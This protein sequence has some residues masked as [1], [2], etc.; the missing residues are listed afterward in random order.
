MVLSS[1][2]D[3]PDSDMVKFVLEQDSVKR[4]SSAVLP[5]INVLV[6]L[7]DDARVGIGCNAGRHRSVII[8]EH[9]ASQLRS[10]D[11][12]IRLV[13]RESQFH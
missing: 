13:H 10:K 1:L 12:E 11:L 3:E 2:F 8:A 4:F 6:E 9:L 5:L 7:D